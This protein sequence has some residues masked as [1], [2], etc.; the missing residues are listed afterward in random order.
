MCTYL[1]NKEASWMIKARNTSSLV[2]MRT[3][4]YML[5]NPNT[6]KTVINQDVIFDEEGEWDWGQHNKDYKFLSI[7]RRI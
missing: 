6:G 7:L 4:G 3:K 2:M 1:M 5:Y